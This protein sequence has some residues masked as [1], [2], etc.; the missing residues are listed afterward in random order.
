ME[1]FRKAALWQVEDHA[2]DWAKEKGLVSGIGEGKFGPGELLTRE[3]VAQL[4]G[5]YPLY[6]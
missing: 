5:K 1:L 3:Q 6:S 2:F 4:T